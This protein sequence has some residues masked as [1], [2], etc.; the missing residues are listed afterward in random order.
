MINNSTNLIAVGAEHSVVICTRT[1]QLRIDNKQLTFPHK[2]WRVVEKLL[3][4]APKGVTRTELIDDIWAGNYYVGEKALNQALWH[5]RKTLGDNANNPQWIKT[6]PGQGYQWVGPD[7][8]HQ[9]IHENLSRQKQPDSK[10]VPNRLSSY[11]SNR[12]AVIGALSMFGIMVLIMATRPIESAPVNSDAASKIMAEN[13]TFAEY[14]QQLITVRV[15][16]SNKLILKTLPD[17]RF[18][19]PV[20]SESG[21][22]LAVR[23]ERRDSCKLVIVN[24]NEQ[25]HQDFEPCPTA[26]LAY[27]RV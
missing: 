15:K 19:Q 6:I 20:F 1:E 27:K 11:F 21:N 14:T 9:D 26:E 5:V 3:Q 4:S 2:T 18:S 12:F 13:G 24:I 16:N 8:N 7:V 23:L 22:E 17:R 10:W 25:T